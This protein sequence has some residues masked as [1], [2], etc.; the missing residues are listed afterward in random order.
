MELMK[1]DDRAHKS[2]QQLQDLLE[3]LA[4]DDTGIVHV[5]KMY[6]AENEDRYYQFAK[7]MQRAWAITAAGMVLALLTGGYIVD[8]MREAATGARSA[9]RELKSTVAENRELI[10]RLEIV[11]E[12]AQKNG[13]LA[14]K[15]LCRKFEDFKVP[16]REVLRSTRSTQFLHLFKRES[17]EDLPN[18]Q[19]VTP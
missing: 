13:G 19:P 14:T 2:L 1:R 10:K 18:A 3:K 6:L 15:M 11:A 12:E 16:V 9:T 5:F 17:C 7:K 8:Q 4:E